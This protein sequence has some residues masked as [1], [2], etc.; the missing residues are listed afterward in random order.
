MKLEG[1]AIL[2]RGSNMEKETIG[3]TTKMSIYRRIDK[4]FLI[5]KMKCYIARK[6]SKLLQLTET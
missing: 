5:H 6:K 1:R 3:E 4:L 2:G